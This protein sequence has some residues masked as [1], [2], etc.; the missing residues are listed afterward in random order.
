M[1]LSSS[2]IRSINRRLARAQGFTWP[3]RDKNHQPT[4]GGTTPVAVSLNMPTVVK[5][6]AVARSA[7]A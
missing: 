3:A 1:R 2:R 4:S 5:I 6:I 7:A